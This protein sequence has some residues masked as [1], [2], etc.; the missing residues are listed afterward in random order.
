MKTIKIYYTPKQVADS[1]AFSPSAAKPAQ[2]VEDWEASNFPLEIVRPQPC[3]TLDI[4]LAHDPEYV[5]GVL[6]CKQSNGFGNTREDVAASL[7]YTTG[8]FVSAAISAFKSGGVAVSPTSGFHHASYF[9]G[10][11]FC[12]FNGLIIAAQKLKLEYDAR[13]VGI[14]DL[15]NHYGN[16]T[17]NIIRHLNLDYIEHFTGGASYHSPKQAKT[18]LRALPRMLREKFGATVPGE[19]IARSGK[20]KDRKKDK[21]AIDILLYQAGADPH[22]DDPLGGWLTTEQ[23]EER[24]RIVF[25]TMADMGIPV[26]WNLA[27][28]YQKE[29]DGSIPKVLEIHNNTLRACLE[30]YG[31]IEK[32]VA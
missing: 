9:H 7:P 29:E 16:G 23:L 3:S 18:F 22:I 27:G 24:D 19:T 14:L 30:V 11:G 8:S 13:R 25:E 28:G 21:P 31:K 10:G 4:C 6:E 26:A 32:G 2:V 17:D 1:G 15:D 20:L 5:K 12:T